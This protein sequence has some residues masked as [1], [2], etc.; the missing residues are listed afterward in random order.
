MLGTRNEDWNSY[1]LVIGVPRDFMM[2]IPLSAGAPY[3]EGSGETVIGEVAA[4]QLGIREGQ[5][6]SLDGTEVRISGVFRTGSRLLDGGF[7]MDIP[8][9]QSILTQE[10]AP[11]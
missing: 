6:V 11:A 3:E 2:R 9:A 8:Q 7:M 5:A 4:G 1:V 10:G